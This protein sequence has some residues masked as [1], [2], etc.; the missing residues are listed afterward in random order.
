MDDS[1]KRFTEAQENT[2]Y[3][4]FSEIQHGKKKSHWMWFIFP[5][6]D[7]L[8]FSETSRYYAIRDLT[9]AD[10]FLKHFVLGPRLINISR[11]LL[12]LK[13]NDAHQVFGSPDD[14]KLQSCMTLFS[15]LE[16]TDPVFK[17]VLN[18]FFNGQKDTKTMHI[19]SHT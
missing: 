17:M 19:I 4:A 10:R 5:Q 9:E 16:N 8:G 11:E 6:I 1:L 14:L 3:A 18:K 12:K 7:G 15:S 13:T 2:Y